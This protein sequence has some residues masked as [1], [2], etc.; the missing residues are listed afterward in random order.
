MLSPAMGKELARKDSAY[1][2]Q[3]CTL[4]STLAVPNFILNMAKR[5]QEMQIYTQRDVVA[6]PNTNYANQVFPPKPGRS[7]V[8]IV[9]KPP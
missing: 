1:S 2:N 9:R 3:V 7:G 5:P 8:I 4:T 6:P